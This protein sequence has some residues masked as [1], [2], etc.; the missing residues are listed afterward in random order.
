MLDH[1][2]HTVNAQ[3]FD[4]QA[5]P[6]WR[7]RRAV[8]GPEG[9]CS[10]GQLASS[11]QDAEVETACSCLTGDGPSSST[12]RTGRDSMASTPA[13]IGMSPASRNMKPMPRPGPVPMTLP[14]LPASAPSAASSGL[15]T[16]SASGPATTATI[17]TVDQATM[18]TV[19]MTLPCIPDGTVACQMAAL[20]ALMSGR[21]NER[22][23]VATAISGTEGAS[24]SREVKAPNT[25]PAS[26]TSFMRRLG[27]PQTIIRME[28]RMTAAAT[29]YTMR[30]NDS[31][32][33]KL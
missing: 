33:A 20:A 22:P 4:S 23:N 17:G 24:P 29:R 21:Q 19:A 9:G 26:R 11:I 1:C 8:H 31:V 28:P 14:T 7:G 18:R 12:V 15:K 10:D 16:W 3:R 27:P 25:I 2:R 30:T 6:P 5:P 32:D 13:T